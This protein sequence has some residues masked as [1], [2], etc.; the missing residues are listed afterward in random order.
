MKERPIP[1]PKFCPAG[2]IICRGC[3]WN[4]D[5]GPCGNCGATAPARDFEVQAWRELWGVQ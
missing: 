4:A 5:G 2:R 3:G 1:D